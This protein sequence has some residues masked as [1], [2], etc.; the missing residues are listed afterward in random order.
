MTDGKDYVLFKPIHDS[1]KP[2]IMEP[3]YNRLCPFHLGDGHSDSPS[4]EGKKPET[5][6]PPRPKDC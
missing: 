2:G 3:F 5:V 6:I 4:Y 1:R